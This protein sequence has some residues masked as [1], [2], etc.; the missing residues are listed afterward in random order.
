MAT[1]VCS[2][3]QTSRYL[4]F[5]RDN[6][7]KGWINE[8]TGETKS[9]VTAIQPQ[10]YR[11]LAF[12]GI[13]ILTPTILSYMNDCPDRFPVIDFYLSLCDKERITCFLPQKLKMMDVG[14]L[15][16]LKDAEH[17]LY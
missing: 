15:N 12:A 2:N 4:L 6:H 10:N 3:R 9:P 8:M 11:K 1:L 13:H 7:L 16:S 14:K 17:F 5:D